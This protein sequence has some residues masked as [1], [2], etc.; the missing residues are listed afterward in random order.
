MA[1]VSAAFNDSNGVRGDMK[2]VLT[3]VLMNPEARDSAKASDPQWGKLREPLV[4]FGTW[5]RAFD[6]KSAQG[7]YAI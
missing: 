2:A 4:R 3:A 6:A 1:Q 7:N 5:M